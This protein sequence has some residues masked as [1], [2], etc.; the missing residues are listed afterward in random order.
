MKDCSGYRPRLPFFAHTADRAGIAM[1]G[2]RM[3]DDIRKSTEA[4]F[5][6]DLVKPIAID[7]LI[8]ATRRV[9]ETRG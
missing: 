9:T 6:E 8:A 7:Q 1:S 2:Y 3:E 5:S 4:G